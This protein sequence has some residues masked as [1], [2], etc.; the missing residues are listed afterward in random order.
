VYYLVKKGVNTLY[1][2]MMFWKPPL[3]SLWL[4]G[5]DTYWRCWLDKAIL[6]D[7]VNSADKERFLI[8]IMNTTQRTYSYVLLKILEPD[9]VI[10][11][12]RHLCSS[13]KLRSVQW[14]LITDVSEDIL[15]LKMT[16][17]GCPESSINNCHFTLR[18]FERAQMSKTRPLLPPTEL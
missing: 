8:Q 2:H 12:F 4:E 3:S 9:F 6:D 17:I 15:L 5:N 1:G 7:K 14:L 16:P 11:G 10:S 13:G 18:N